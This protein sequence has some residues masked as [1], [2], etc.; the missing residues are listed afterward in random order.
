VDDLPQDREAVL[1]AAAQA[2]RALSLPGSWLSED[3]GLHA[4]TLPEGWEGRRVLVGTFARLRVYTASRPDLIAMK[5]IAHCERDLEHLAQMNV[6]QAE[7][8]FVL[9]YLE[10]LMRQY[11]GEAARIEMARQYVDAWE[12][13]S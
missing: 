8:P 11:P 10:A 7:L 4:W 3:V 9:R 6:G 1:V 12:V 2:G 5:F 13:Q